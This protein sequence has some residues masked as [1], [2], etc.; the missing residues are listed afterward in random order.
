MKLK[1]LATILLLAS[2]QMAYS[3][4][5]ATATLL[6]CTGKSWHQDHSQWNT[7]GIVRITDQGIHI[8]I[9]SVGSGLS[10]EQPKMISATQASGSIS[11]LPP[12]SGQSR[13][14]VRYTLNKYSGQL[15]VTIPNS[16]NRKP[17]FSG[18]C[19]PAEPLF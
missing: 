13:I 4:E 1:A 3:A 5:P 10:P 16:K 17:L 7:D 6:Y 14:T 8:D 15:W 12:Q 19:K 18:S 2:A 9:S 11:L